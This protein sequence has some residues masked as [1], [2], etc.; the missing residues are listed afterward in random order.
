LA[1]PAPRRPSSQVSRCRSATPTSQGRSKDWTGSGAW[2]PTR[3][4]SPSLAG[5]RCCP[6]FDR[7]VHDRQR[8]IELFDFDY[9]L[10]VFKAAAKRGSDR[11]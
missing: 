4:I 9:I 3:S 2:I 1:W 7:L 11:S 6:P 5:R 10:E 8:T